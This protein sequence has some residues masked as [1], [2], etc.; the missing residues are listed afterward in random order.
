MIPLPFN[1]RLALFVDIGNVYGFAAP[2]DITRLNADIG[3][4]LRWL[5]PF[6]PLRVDYGIKVLKDSRTSQDNDFGAIQFSVGAPF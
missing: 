4:G 5:S 1:L 6:G 2:F 3:A